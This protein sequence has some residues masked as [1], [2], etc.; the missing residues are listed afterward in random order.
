MLAPDGYGA[1]K[2]AD[3][4]SDQPISLDDEADFIEPILGSVSAPFFWWVTP[5]VLQLHSTS[6]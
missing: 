1:G 4:T 2:S 3:W 5:T 6:H